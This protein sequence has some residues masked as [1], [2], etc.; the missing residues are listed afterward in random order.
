VRDLAVVHGGSEWGIATLSAGVAAVMPAPSDDAPDALLR[1][2]DRALYLAKAA[3]RNAVALGSM[4]RAK[5][6]SSVAA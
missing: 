1:E 3:G 4:A 2:A 6:A 5:V